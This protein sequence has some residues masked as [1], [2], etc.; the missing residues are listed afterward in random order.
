MILRQSRKQIRRAA[1][2]LF[3]SQMVEARTRENRR[4][5][6]PFPR[7]SLRHDCGLPTA[8]GFASSPQ[9][10]FQTLPRNP[11]RSARIPHAGGPRTAVDCL[12]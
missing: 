12:G 2:Y 8:Q 1:V 10:F 6:F 7:I 3:L 11:S 9:A 5:T 4:S